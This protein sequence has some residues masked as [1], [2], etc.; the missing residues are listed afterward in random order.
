MRYALG[1]EYDGSGFQG[2]QRLSKSGTPDETSV[3]SVLENA[4]SRV[5]NAQVDTICAGRTDAGVHAQ[6]QVVHFDSDAPRDPRSWVLGA[7]ANLPPAVCVRWCQ[8]MP[9]DFNARFSARARR[10]RYRLVNRIVRPALER[11]MLSWERM[12][13]DADA[14]HRAAQAL[15]GEN[16]FNAFRT[17]HCQSPHA[18]RDLQAI[19]VRREGEQVRVDVQANAFLHHMVRNIVGS[20]LVVGRGEKPESWIAELLAGRDRTVAGPTAPPDGLV[21]VSPLYPS[22][23]RLPPEVTLPD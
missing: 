11:H 19:S 15:L 16:D 22:H 20:L 6:C 2:W 8:P 5:A 12:P 18:F 23:W 17:V 7:T 9:D 3:Q 14:M 13:L 21:F 4:L 10:Y 1:V